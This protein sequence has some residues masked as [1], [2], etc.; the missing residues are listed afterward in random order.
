M[1]YHCSCNYVPGVMR[2]FDMGVILTGLIAPRP[3]VIVNGLND[4]IFPIDSA[5]REYETTEKALRGLGRAGYVPPY[6]RARGTPLLCRARLAGVRRAD[7][8]ELIEYDA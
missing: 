2:S 1:Q 8:L 6:R 7:R 3:L 4:T 5:N